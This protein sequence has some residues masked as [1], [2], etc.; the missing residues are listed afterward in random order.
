MRAITLLF[1]I[2]FLLPAAASQTQPPAKPAPA[3]RITEIVVKGNSAVSK[4]AILAASGLAVGQTLYQPALDAAATKLVAMNAFG[5]GLKNPSDAV[6]VTSETKG[7][8]ARIL[9]Q[10]IE[11]PVVK[12]IVFDGPGPVDPKDIQA[13]MHTKTGAMLDLHKLQDDLGAIKEEFETGGFQAFIGEEVAVKEGVLTI[14]ITVTK[15]HN[16]TL[17]GLRRRDPDS[18]M[19]LIKS[20]KDSYYNVKRLKEDLEELNKTGFFRAVEPQFSFP[21]PGQVDLTIT[22][23]ERFE[24]R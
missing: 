14:P 10:V 17:A 23:R 22:F 5:F 19:K 6:K 3:A 21:A 11:N 24:R 15:I 18:M 13:I 8:K 2:G 1:A 7:K 9:I 16:L 4:S 12:S 20:Q